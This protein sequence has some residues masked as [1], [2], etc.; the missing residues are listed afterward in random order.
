MRLPY[1]CTIVQLNLIYVIK[2]VQ[3]IFIFI[4][5]HAAYWIWLASMVL[6]IPVCIP[7]HFNVY[8]NCLSQGR[9]VPEWCLLTHIAQVVFQ[10]GV[11]WHGFVGILTYQSM[12]VLL[13][14]WDLFELGVDDSTNLVH[15]SWVMYFFLLLKFPSFCPSF[16]WNISQVISDF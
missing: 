6:L 10:L 7:N 5:E 8:A 16:W 4:D 9:L 14:L 2:V 15:I 12:S 11:S 3:C 13:H 1:I